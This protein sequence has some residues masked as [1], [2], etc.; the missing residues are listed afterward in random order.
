MILAKCPHCNKQFRT[1]KK[2][3]ER[4]NCP[5]CT[6][7]FVIDETETIE[8]FK[9][10]TAHVKSATASYMMFLFYICLYGG[11]ATALFVDIIHGISLFLISG[12]FIALA[13]IIKLLVCVSKNCN[14]KT[15]GKI[16]EV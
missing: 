8:V 12:L 5:E 6:R 9:D 16:G 13:K 7:S 4:V 1:H 14:V 2:V 15:E 10:N 3:N 11:I